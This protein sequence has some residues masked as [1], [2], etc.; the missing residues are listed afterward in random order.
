M[1]YCPMHFSSFGC[2]VQKHKRHIHCPVEHSHETA[3]PHGPAPD[4][5][6]WAPCFAIRACG[7]Q[8]RAA[9]FLYHLR[10]APTI[11]QPLSTT[12]GN[13]FEHAR[14]A[15]FPIPSAVPSNIE[16]S[17]FACNTTALVTFYRPHGE[18]HFNA[19]NQQLLKSAKAFPCNCTLARV[20]IVKAPLV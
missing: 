8:I 12:I 1:I 11:A 19:T 20:R 7:L 17:L 4:V 15:T 3:V 18:F 2:H 14:S 16:L 10:T 5:L 13:T 6:S 9:I